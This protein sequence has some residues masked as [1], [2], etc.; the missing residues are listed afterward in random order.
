MAKFDKTLCSEAELRDRIAQSLAQAAQ[1]V[2][3]DQDSPADKS[4]ID[5]LRRHAEVC[6]AELARRGLGG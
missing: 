6:K 4:L 1:M 2:E 3:E 5:R